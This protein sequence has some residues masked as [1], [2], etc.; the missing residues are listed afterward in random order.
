MLDSREHPIG[1]TRARLCTGTKT[2]PLGSIEYGEV[3]HSPRG[4]QYLKRRLEDENLIGGAKRSIFLDLVRFRSPCCARTR[5]SVCD[6]AGH[7]GVRGRESPKA[8]RWVLYAHA[9]LKNNRDGV[10]DD[11]TVKRSSHSDVVRG[12]VHLKP[13]TLNRRCL[14][15]QV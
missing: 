14:A 11:R 15:R 4:L 6:P 7:K 9:S 5:S 12:C 10:E 2:A 13:R 3:R 8:F 1:C